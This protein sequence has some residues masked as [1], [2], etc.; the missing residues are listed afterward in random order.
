MDALTGR[1]ADGR[2]RLLGA[3]VSRT[4]GR[5]FVSFTV[6]TDREIPAQP[7]QRQ[8]TGGTVGVDLG[9]KHLAVLSTGETVANPQRHAASL[10]KLRRASR[11]YARSRPGSAGRRKRAATL[12]RIH[13][14]VANQRRDELHKLTTRLARSHDVIVAEDLHVAGMVR[15][16]RLARAVSDTAMGEIRRQL[17]YKSAWCGSPACTSRTAGI[18]PRRPAPAVAGETQA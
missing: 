11:A 10:R 16:R 4:A 14:R 7:S 5:W 12:A 3:T 8:R 6:E 18:H 17:A 1:L 9:V 15:N 2:A 13:A